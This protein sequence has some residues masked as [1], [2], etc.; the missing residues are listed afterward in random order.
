MSPILQRAPRQTHSSLLWVS[1]RSPLPRNSSL[2]SNFAVKIGLVQNRLGHRIT[3]GFSMEKARLAHAV[4]WAVLLSAASLWA[5]AG[6]TT[7]PSNPIPSGKQEP[8]WKQVGIS[9]SALQQRRQIAE[10]THSQVE[11]VC[12]NSSLTAQQK[13]QQ[14]RQIRQ[15][16]HA[17]MDKLVSPSQMEALK[18]CR[19]KRGLGSTSPAASVGGPC[20]DMPLSGKGKPQP[21]TN[22]QKG[23]NP[24]PEP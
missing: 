12:A 19:A 13:L 1:S 20:G 5:Q 18:S 17:K 15:Q 3:R 10:Q 24:E 16:A 14:I 9:Q 22:P 11:A 8:C 6:R 7:A 23:P 4:A 2:L 21:G